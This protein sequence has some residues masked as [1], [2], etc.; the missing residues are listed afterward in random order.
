MSPDGKIGMLMMQGI[1]GIAERRTKKC[2]DA[3]EALEELIQS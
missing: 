2:M 1:N 3:T